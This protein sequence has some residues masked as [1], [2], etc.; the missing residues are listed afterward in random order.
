MKVAT[1]DWGNADRTAYG[2][3]GDLEVWGPPAYLFLSASDLKCI[4]PGIQAGYIYYAGDFLEDP[5][6]S[7]V[8]P[9]YR[10]EVDNTQGYFVGITCDVCLTDKISLDLAWMEVFEADVDA[11]AYFS[12]GNKVGRYGTFPMAHDMASIGMK[13]SF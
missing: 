5:A 3:D 1:R 11:R 6:W 12:P 8:G 13:Y 7:A 4:K 2:T 9:G 10:F